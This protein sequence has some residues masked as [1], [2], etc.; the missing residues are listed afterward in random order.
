MVPPPAIDDGSTR[1]PPS[2]FNLYNESSTSR[3][4]SLESLSNTPAGMYLRR[5]SD[6][7]PS[8]VSPVQSQDAPFIHE[9]GPPNA[10]FMS[11][12]GH[13]HGNGHGQNSSPS[14]SVYHG[15]VGAHLASKGS[16]NDL[17][18]SRNNSLTF[19][20]PFLSPAS[21]PTSNI[22]SNTWNPP[23]YPQTRPGSPTA[24]STALAFTQ[25]HSGK[26]PFQSALL[27]E[28]IPKEDKP[29]LAKPAPRQRASYWFTLFGVFLG[30]A[31]AA[32]LCFFE[33]RSLNLLDESQL[34]TVFFDDFTSG[35]LDTSI[36]SRTVELGGFGN[37]EFEIMTN[38]DENLKIENSQL[39]LIP[40]LTSASIGNT[41]A[42]FNG[43]TYD[44]GDDCTTSNETACS[45][46]SDSSTK[47]VIPPVQSARIST[48]GTYSLKYGRVQVRAKTPTGD[49]LWPSIW[50]LPVNNTYGAW[51]LSGEIDIMESRG[52]SITYPDQG[53]NYVRSSLNY[54]PLA[55]LL[56][57]S[58]MYGWWFTKRLDSSSWNT[59]FHTYTLEWTDQWMR[60]YVDSRL[61]A[62]LDISLKSSK[63]SFFNRA[64]YPST[65]INSSSGDTVA[66]ENIYDEAG[67]GWN[68][69]FDQEFYLIIQL[70]VGGTSGWFPDGAGGKMWTD[71]STEAMYDFAEAQD[72]WYASWP[73]SE[74]D[75]ALRVDW[76]KMWNMC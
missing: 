8:P 32:L 11:E 34:C 9:L 19:R 44:L 17:S 2:S 30:L 31:G 41:S 15:S 12:S 62:M 3:R 22:A 72:E 54:A 42:I 40:T 16:N 75:K 66:V 13:G 56:S 18:R 21:R 25:R 60:M 70:A 37:G 50:M 27:S 61:Q 38:K 57:Q 33:L 55:S 23:T 6:E 47:T 49:W 29:W 35:S 24:S 51:P 36:W 53:V 1:P 14:N 45:V 5:F 67:G 64:G 52:N 65:A 46:T 71:G 4:T 39:Y 73:T 10:P 68:A 58:T 63:E 20:A 59:G 43:Y 76:V 26:Q 48:N 7:V 74:D 28:K 69:P